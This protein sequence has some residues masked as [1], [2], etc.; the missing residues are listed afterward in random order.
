MSLAGK[1]YWTVTDSRYGIR[2]AYDNRITSPFFQTAIES[3]D[4]FTK[5]YEYPVNETTGFR[6]KMKVIKDESEAEEDAD[7]GDELPDWEFDWKAAEEA[8]NPV[9][10]G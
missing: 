8:L 6:G 5:D 2:A 1:S 3:L 4:V 10:E 9:Q 7:P